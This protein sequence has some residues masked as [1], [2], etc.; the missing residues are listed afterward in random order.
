MIIFQN[1]L[2]K[3]AKADATGKYDTE[4]VLHFE[5]PTSSDETGKDISES[6]DVLEAQ[7]QDTPT[8]APEKEV[9]EI[10]SNEPT[11][12][13]IPVAPPKTLACTGWRQTG[14][15]SPD[16]PREPEFDQKCVNTVS[17][18]W[19]GY[20]ECAGG[21]KR[22]MVGCNHVAFKCIEICSSG[23]LH[24]IPAERP[25]LEGIVKEMD[26]VFAKSIWTPLDQHNAHEFVYHRPILPF[27]M[28]LK[29]DC[30]RD[31]MFAEVLPDLDLA[32]APYKGKIRF[33]S[34]S[35]TISH[36]FGSLSR[37][38]LTADMLPT[39][40]SDYLPVGA[41]IEKSS[42]PINKQ[43]N[44]DDIVQYV[45]DAVI[46]RV[47]PLV[48]K[49]ETSPKEDVYEK[50]VLKVT[51]SS[52]DEQVIQNSKAVLIMVYGKVLLDVI[53][54]YICDESILVISFCF[55]LVKS[56]FFYI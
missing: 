31:A 39:L 12:A 9:S 26:E 8:E 23:D 10:L 34:Q 38:S 48:I 1:V 14:A 2:G 52:F 45:E 18:A 50:G 3:G 56:N 29:C 15:C 20:C 19:S 46:T 11:A 13:P 54:F 30:P 40:V 42:F 43:F 27:I 32:L 41:T 6:Q 5:A 4:P 51:A 37:Y 49:S 55:T 44:V 16:G 22:A 21:I 17:S 7:A 28:L 33:L 35:R 53:P 47:A 25:A 36:A 24:L